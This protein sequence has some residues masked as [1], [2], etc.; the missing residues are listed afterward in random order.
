LENAQQDSKF[1]L[2]KSQNLQKE[3]KDLTSQLHVLSGLYQQQT[4]QLQ[5]FHLLSQQE[6]EHAV[7]MAAVVQ[8]KEEAVRDKLKLRQQLESSLAR[9]EEH[10]VEKQRWERDLK[11][12]QVRKE[13]EMARAWTKIKV[14]H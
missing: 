13:E 14:R 10:E 6:A 9:L 4:D 3:V 5:M 8:E 2:E 12:M 11:R 7:K 1:H